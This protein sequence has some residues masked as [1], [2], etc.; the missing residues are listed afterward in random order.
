[1]ES[2]GPSERAAL[3]EQIRAR[4]EKFAPTASSVT[5]GAALS[6]SNI[7]DLLSFVSNSAVEWV[8]KRLGPEVAVD[9]DQSWIRR[10]YAPD[11]YPPLHAPH[12][13]HQDGALG[14]N[15]LSGSPQTDCSRALLEMITVWIALGPCGT[16]A[17]GLELLACSLNRLLPPHQLLDSRVRSEFA[18]GLFWKP[19]LNGGDALLFS[20]DILHRTHVSPGM[21]RDRSSIELRCF[22][23]S[24][25]PPRLRGDRFLVFL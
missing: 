23:A 25:L 22:P 7:V 8:T 24:R 12:G 18:P 11:R 14:F 15:F 1:L 4:G 5:V 17:P 19:F 16:D 13:W 20:G 3:I 2:A 6:E 21:A 10:Q 9:L